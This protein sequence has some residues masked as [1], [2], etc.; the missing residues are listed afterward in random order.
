MSTGNLGCGKEEDYHVDPEP[1]PKVYNLELRYDGDRLT[2]TQIALPNNVFNVT[3]IIVPFGKVFKQWKETLEKDSYFKGLSIMNNRIDLM[4]SLEYENRVLRPFKDF[5][6]K[7]TNSK[8]N[9][10]VGTPTLKDKKVHLLE[11]LHLV[12]CNSHCILS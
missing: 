7:H 4:K 5:I 2:F 1:E 8:I 6:T 12:H 9:T 3:F 10:L 11:N